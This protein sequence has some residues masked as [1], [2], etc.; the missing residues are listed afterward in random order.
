M[1]SRP[2]YC[3]RPLPPYSYVPGHRPHPVSHPDGHQYGAERP[4]PQRLAPPDWRDS[5]D[6]RH[7]VDLFNHG[8]YWEA[9]EA[10]EGLWL[11]AGRR[12]VVGDFLKGLI[13]R[14]GRRCLELVDCTMQQMAADSS[15]FCGLSLAAVEAIARG[16]VCEAPQRF[17]NPNPD[18]LLESWL[19][20]EGL[21][22]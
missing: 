11:A 16:L 18:L 2:R 17:N 19:T 12:G 7:G 22:E 20:L 10:W 21:D 9:H 8:F 6:F 3:D 5:S 14:H 1:T 15:R 13:N 4:Q